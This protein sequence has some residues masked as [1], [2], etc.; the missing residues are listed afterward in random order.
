MKKITALF[1]FSAIALNILLVLILS[2]YN[3]F[4]FT[5][6]SISIIIAWFLIAYSAN[7]SPNNGFKIGLTFFFS[8]TLLAKLILSLISEPVMKDNPM[9]VILFCI[10]FLEAVVLFVPSLLKKN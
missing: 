5:L 8:V 9:I 6:S 7:N 4:N 1:G 2:H 3:L 10:T